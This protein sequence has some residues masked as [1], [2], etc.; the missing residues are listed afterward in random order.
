M[1]GRRVGPVGR[2]TSP[3]GW[4]ERRVAVTAALAAWWVSSG[5]VERSMYIRTQPP[6]AVVVVNDEEVGLSPVKFN[7]LWYGDY[8][9]VIRKEGFRSLATHY[10]VNAPWYQLPVVDLVAEHLVAG[11]IRDEHVLPTYALEPAS[12]PAVPDLVERAAEM[13]D[14]TLYQGE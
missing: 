4:C 11:T 14:R 3:W 12:Q 7:F 13:R 10:R 5:C 1:D 2:R 9:I 6:G 8:D